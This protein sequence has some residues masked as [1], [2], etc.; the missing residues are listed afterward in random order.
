MIYDRFASLADVFAAFRFPDI[1]L[2]YDQKIVLKDKSVIHM[3]VQ[4][5]FFRRWRDGTTYE[6]FNVKAAFHTIV[7]QS[8]RSSVPLLVEAL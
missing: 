2:K 1:K 3:W 4:T 8:R 5:D 6:S 7:L